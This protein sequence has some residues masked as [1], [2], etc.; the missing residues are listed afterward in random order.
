MMIESNTETRVMTH[1]NQ[2]I[3]RVIDEIDP[4]SCDFEPLTKSMNGAALTDLSIHDQICTSAFNI[5]SSF[6]METVGT[7]YEEEYEQCNHRHRANHNTIFRKTV[8]AVLSMLPRSPQLYNKIRNW[9]DTIAIHLYAPV[10][11]NA[12]SKV[13][14]GPR[15]KGLAELSEASAVMVCLVF[16]I[17]IILSGII[18]G[19]I[20]HIIGTGPERKIA[21]VSQ[22]FFYRH[23]RISPQG[24]GLAPP[25]GTVLPSP[26][27]DNDVFADVDDLPLE[28]L[29]TP[30][31]WHIPRSAGTS[32]KTIFSSCLRKVIATEVGGLDGKGSDDRIVTI[33]NPNGSFVNVDMYTVEGI[34]RAKNL[35][36]VQSNL[37]E[38]LFT[39]FVHESSV[40]FD[41][42][43]RGRWF[44][45]IR[46]PVDRIISLYYFLRIYD[47]NVKKQSMDEFVRKSGQNWMVRTLTGAMVGPI[48]EMHLNAAKEMLRRKFLVGILAKKTE[49]FRRF[50]EYFGWDVASSRSESCKNDIFYFNWH[51]KNPHPMPEEGDAIYIN[52]KKVNALDIALYEY[53]NQLFEEQ[54]AI[55]STKE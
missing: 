28:Y 14:G 26:F 1:R 27:I 36:L 38:A 10:N 18:G 40:L 43:H 6:D 29:D 54:S 16:A 34:E 55:F 23:N 9:I 11:T 3:E 35:D 46:H 13:Q 53:A 31:F 8:M 32:M 49:S 50:E 12:K 21:V 51:L 7:R 30:I 19:L 17:V 15:I 47:N 41:K 44:T 37:A 42:N 22:S 20:S 45:I 33:K 24:V 52:L 48:D 39:P 4:D 2:D 5:S 25:I